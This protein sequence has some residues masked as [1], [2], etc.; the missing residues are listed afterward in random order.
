MK[1]R[2]IDHSDRI[3]HNIKRTV[4][5]SLTGLLG[6][7][8][9]LS[10]VYT[11]KPE[12][13]GV[14]KRLGSYYETASPGIHLKAPFGIDE[15]T[16]VPIRT[17]QKEEFGFRTLKSGIDSQ[18]I[19][20]ENTQGEMKKQL[21]A[22]GLMLTGDL[23]IVY[24]ESVVQYNIKDPVSFLFNIREPR[25][26]LRDCYESVIRQIIGDESFD[27]AISISRIENQDRAKIM[28]QELL[29]QYQTG[30][31]VIT[32]NLQSCNPPQE[33]RSAFNNVNQ[34]MQR[35]D[36]RINEAK[37]EYN[38]VI[39][40]A[41]GES[42]ETIKKA[43]AY[44][45]E[46]V[47]KAKGDVASFNEVYAAYKEDPQITRERLYFETM[48][49]VLPRIEHKWVVDQS[50]LDNGLVNLLQLNEKGDKK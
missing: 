35:K 18:F 14:I 25:E 27:E 16:K 46:R 48:G 28:L 22:E 50:G 2:T 43:R 21:E 5:W 47:N 12:E 17:V 13:A 8:A 39:A 41:T 45:I 26:T 24:L 19:S 29:D 20:A 32:V 1:N 23:N 30:I 6:A 4:K 31:K 15:L 7:A 44:A 38:Q 9:I 36:Q 40:L 49:T 3:M 33:V 34:A 11:I 42:E 37:R 10:S